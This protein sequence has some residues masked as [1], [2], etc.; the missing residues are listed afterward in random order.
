MA[1]LTDIRE[2]MASRLKEIPGLFCYDRIPGR[3]EPPAAVVG[4][5]DP[6]TYNLTYGPTAGT[7]LI[8]VR[9]YVARVDAEEAQSILDQYIAPTG[10]QSIKAALEATTVTGCWHSLTVVQVGEF[11]SYEIGG[12]PYLGCQFTTE[13]IAS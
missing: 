7:Y 2:D 8:P 11:G 9:L 10:S 4:M 3:I 13:V 12:V 1:S 6:L 5:P